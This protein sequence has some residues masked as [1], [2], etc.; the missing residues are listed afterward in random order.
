MAEKK[1]GIGRKV[2]HAGGW[3]VAKRVAKMVPFGGTRLP[4]NTAVVP[5][6][7]DRRSEDRQIRLI[8]A[9]EVDGGLGV[10]GFTFPVVGDERITRIGCIR[11]SGNA[12]A[13]QRRGLDG[14][15]YRRPGTERSGREKN[16]LY[17]VDGVG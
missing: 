11:I 13:I 8:V 4:V 14:D 17:I 10:L 5:P 15:L 7:T 9:V 16:V 12:V 3:Q 1:H 6:F 2:L